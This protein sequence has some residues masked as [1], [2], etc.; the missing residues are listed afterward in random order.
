MAKEFVGDRL[1]RFVAESR[2]EALPEALR[3]EAKRSLLN[4][5]GCAIGSAH[6]E[7]VAIATRV[8]VPLSGAERVTVFGRSERLDPLGATFISRL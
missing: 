3:H 4:F 8:L 2:W 7:P 5:L 6:T 1:G